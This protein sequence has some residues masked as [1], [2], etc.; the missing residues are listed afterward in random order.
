M[1]ETRNSS[2]S[3]LVGLVIKLMHRLSLI[4]PL[5]IRAIPGSCSVK[6]ISFQASYQWPSRYLLPRSPNPAKSAPHCA[7]VAAPGG[8][9]FWAS[10]RES[11]L[12]HPCR[13][14]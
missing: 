7:E 14:I 2:W 11:Q 1:D 5:S 4:L 3:R 12:M 9:F 8:N 13:C 6:A 10:P